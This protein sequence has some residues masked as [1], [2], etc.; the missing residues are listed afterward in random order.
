[1]QSFVNYK[2]FISNSLNMTLGLIITAKKSSIQMDQF[3]LFLVIQP[4]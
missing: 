3:A 4:N 2:I 1:M